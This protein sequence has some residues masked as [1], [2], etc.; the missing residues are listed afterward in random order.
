MEGIVAKR[1][2]LSLFDVAIEFN[3]QDEILSDIKAIKEIFLQNQDFF[4]IMTIPTITKG[5][6]IKLLDNVF[7]DKINLYVLNF[8]KI[9]VEKG[10]INHFN[11]IVTSFNKIYNTKNNIKEVVAITAIPLNDNLLLKLKSKL[12]E[13]TGKKIVL[14]NEVDKSIMGGVVLKME[15]D[16]LDGSI[17][18]R[19]N[20]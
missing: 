12:E 7:G 5:E 16:Q 20:A 15:D 4:K 8:L 2:A 13:I 19:L 14:F 18:G 17:K 9:L 11:E 3:I 1:Y 10:R 6:K